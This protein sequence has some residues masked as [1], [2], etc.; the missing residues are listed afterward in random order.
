MIV[1]CMLWVVH[2]MGLNFS[3]SIHL[4]PYFVHASSQGSG[5]TVQVRMTVWLFA[6]S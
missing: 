2:P 6:G 4:H 3:V 1:G 5:E